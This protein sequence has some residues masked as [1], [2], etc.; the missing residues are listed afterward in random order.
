MQ[1]QFICS[2]FVYLHKQA[3]ILFSNHRVEM[4]QKNTY[5][6]WNN[7]YIKSNIKYIEKQSDIL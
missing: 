5:A 7:R 2:L 4:I 3:K 1:C 6:K